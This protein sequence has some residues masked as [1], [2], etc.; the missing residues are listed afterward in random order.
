MTLILGAVMPKAVVHVSDRL[1]SK[2]RAG[3]YKAHDARSNKTIIVVAEG[4]WLVL[5]Y[6]GQAYFGSQPTD[7]YLASAIS[8]MRLQGNTVMGPMFDSRGV[9][10]REVIGR[11]AD[12]LR[13]ASVPTTVLV[14]GYYNVSDFARQ[15][16]LT[17]DAAGDSTVRVCSRLKTRR[18]PV[19]YFRAG[20]VGWVDHDVLQRL[21]GVEQAISADA[22][23]ETLRQG[24]VQLVIDT[25]SR[26]IAVS[27]DTASV[28]LLPYEGRGEVR[29]HALKPIGQADLLQRTLSADYRDR[30]ALCTPY[31]LIGGRGIAEPTVATGNFSTGARYGPN[32]WVHFDITGYDMDT[33]TGRF[34]A[35][36]QVRTTPPRR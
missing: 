4:C 17:V 2:E 3:K 34:G 7:Q 33:S 30:S 19:H 21:R 36:P 26:D 9:G 22:P 20:A 27:Q 25:A 35:G 31:I 14:T 15:L 6:T 24:L 18:Q 23:A 12:A 28:V 11:T 29:F 32:S 10:Y 8:G 1:I 13:A 5:G 16:L